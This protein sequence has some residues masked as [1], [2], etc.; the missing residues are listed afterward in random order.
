M[1]NKRMFST[2]LLEIFTAR[3]VSC[4]PVGVKDHVD[5]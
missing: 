3:N 4:V 2:N 1:V 5:K